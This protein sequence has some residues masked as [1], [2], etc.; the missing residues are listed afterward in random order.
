MR[1]ILLPALVVVSALASVTAQSKLAPTPAEY[2]QF[3][4]I[5]PQARGGLSP[6]GRWLAYGINRSSRDNEL[7]ITQIADGTTKTAA[8]GTQP[9]FSSDSKWAAYAIGYSEAQEGKLR[10]Q[11]NPVQRKLGLLTLASGETSTIDAIESFAFAPT[12]T[13]LAMRRYPPE[14]PAAAAGS[15]PAA[16]DDTPAGAT[17]I[18]REL[19]SG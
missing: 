1:R 3:E 14:R 12:G 19:A 2:G 15:A 16:S 9:A 6:D 18:V 13:H 10:Q 8:F 17:L 11:K 4:T 7:R 5:A